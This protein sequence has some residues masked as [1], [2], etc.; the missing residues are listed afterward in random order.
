MK[1]FSQ[2]LDTALNQRSAAS[3][4]ARTQR[5]E[6]ACKWCYADNSSPMVTVVAFVAMGTLVLFASALVSALL[7]TQ[8]VFA[9][10]SVIGLALMMVAP[11]LLFFWAEKANNLCLTLRSTTITPT[12]IVETIR[13]CKNAGATEE[14]IL[15]LSLA[16][17]DTTTPSDWWFWIENAANEQLTLARESQARDNQ[18]LRNAQAQEQIDTGKIL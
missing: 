3:R 13:L 16:A 17:K 6:A 1:T 11:T 14:Q 8:L 4:Y 18:D 7:N 9:V 5:F 10:G 12:Q 2:Q 15:L